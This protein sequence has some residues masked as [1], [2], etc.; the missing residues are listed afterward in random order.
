MLDLTGRDLLE[1][2]PRDLLGPHHDL[3]V[4]MTA[5]ELALISTAMLLGV[6]IHWRHGQARWIE[7]RLATELLRGLVD[8]SSPLVR[9]EVREFKELGRSDRILAIIIAGEP[10]ADYPAKACA[11]NRHHV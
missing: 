9:K 5:S 3:A 7:L 1:P 6:F 10:N 11:S 8:S 2:Q 4:F